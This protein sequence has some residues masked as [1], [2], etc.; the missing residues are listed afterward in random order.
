[1]QGNKGKFLFLEPF[2]GGSHRD[3]LEGLLVHTAHQIH[4]LIMRARFW[5]WRMSGAAIH[6]ARRLPADMDSYD[7]V[8]VSGLMSLSDLIALAPA[9]LPPSL[10]YFHENQLTYPVSSSERRD[11]QPAWIN[12]TTALTSDRILFNSFAHMNSF[13]GSL[14]ALIRMMPDYRQGWITEAIQKKSSVLY[15]GCRFSD[16]EFPLIE[17]GHEEPPLI[18]W[19]HRWE[20]DKNPGPFFQALDRLLRKGLEFRLALLGQRFRNVPESFRRARRRY[21]DRI[22]QYGF[23]KSREEY[24]EWLKQGTLVVSTAIQENFGIAVIEAVRH[25]CLPVLPNRL[26]YPELI[27][28]EF[29]AFFLYDDQE[30]LEKRLSQVIERPRHFIALREK[31]SHAMARFSWERQIKAYDNEL[32]KLAEC[33]KSGTER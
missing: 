32:N 21:S 9:P 17:W 15:P 33:N 23:V 12:I 19:N 5:K 18:I 8:I 22:V 7:G 2:N 25:G 6:F 14:R 1:M 16:G 10:V 26:S 29:H 30:G 13:L 24:I 27:P 28:E 31:L 20:H 11:L 3:F 4:P